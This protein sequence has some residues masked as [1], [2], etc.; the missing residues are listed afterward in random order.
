MQPKQRKFANNQKV[1]KSTAWWLQKPATQRKGTKLMSQGFL[2]EV[3]VLSLIIACN[4][5]GI[6]EHH[7]WNVFIF[8]E[9]IKKWR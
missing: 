7:A 2:L 6:L 8:K 5:P 4:E 3:S 9:Q 1:V